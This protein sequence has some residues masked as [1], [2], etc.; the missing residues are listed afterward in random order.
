M[1]A[2]SKQRINVRCVKGGGL[3][4]ASRRS[5]NE[6]TQRQVV[7]QLQQ[8]GLC[9]RV[10]LAC[11]QDFNVAY[12]HAI[13]HSVEINLPRLRIRYYILVRDHCGGG[14]I[15]KN[16]DDLKYSFLAIMFTSTTPTLYG[17]K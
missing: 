9:R 8:L 10:E 17:E 14:T 16:V 15:F 3:G 13:R 2:T 7:R 6:S 11:G 1:N 4:N 5:T 12:Q